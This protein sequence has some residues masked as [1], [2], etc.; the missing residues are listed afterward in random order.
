[1]A[2]GAVWASALG[3][4]GMSLEVWTALRGREA[5]DLSVRDDNT[6]V[7]SSN[8]SPRGSVPRSLLPP[9]QRV[10]PLP[11]RSR[12]RHKATPRRPG[13]VCPLRW[14]AER[15]GGY[16]GL[17]PPAAREQ[18]Q[19][20]CVVQTRATAARGARL[21]RRGCG[22]L[23]AAGKHRRVSQRPLSARQQSNALAT[24]RAHK[25]AIAELACAPAPG[26]DC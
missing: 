7:R 5:T 20:R 22:A 24:T 6:G 13:L 26:K 2:T 23:A 11:T 25:Q 10:R 17:D 8:G 16:R 12:A 1:M 18:L 14:R 4:C 3:T 15:R 19:W 21:R 9:V